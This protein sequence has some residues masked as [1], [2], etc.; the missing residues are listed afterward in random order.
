[1]LGASKSLSAMSAAAL[2]AK[3]VEALAPA[4]VVPLTPVEHVEAARE[5]FASIFTAAGPAHDLVD[6]GTE[7]VNRAILDMKVGNWL[8]LV[9]AFDDVT[10]RHCLTV[11]GLA[12]AFAASLHFNPADA[13]LLTKGA[14]LHD[15]GKARI[16]LEILNK[17]G[18]LTVPERKIMAQHAQIGFE[19]LE[20]K[21]FSDTAMRVVRSHHE[22]L[23]GAGYPDGLRGEEIPDIVRLVTI[24][25]IF[26]ALIER[27]TY[28]A[29]MGAR[30]AYGIML[31]M[32]GK[33]DM[34][35]LRAF[36]P[37]PSPATSRTCSF[38]PEG[39]DQFPRRPVAHQRGDEGVIEVVAGVGGDDEPFHRIPDEGEVAHDVEHPVADE[40]VLHA[41]APDHPVAEQERRRARPAALEQRL[42]R[43]EAVGPPRHH[44]HEAAEAPR[45]GDLLLEALGGDRSLPIERAETAEFDMRADRQAASG[46]MDSRRCPSRC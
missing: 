32:T 3:T 17:P 41:Q 31:D 10:H 27:R 28:K 5:A 21:G 1:M 42:A 46:P 18:P 39:S 43:Q 2:L 22:T 36:G 11:A 44:A 34:D 35:L 26:A 33:L 29:P 30:T 13:H 4:P 8:S 19:M 12:A 38:R 20:G 9:A 15:I 25:D 37:W 40:F 7:I 45:G 23:D 6:H 14:L 24:C 16:P